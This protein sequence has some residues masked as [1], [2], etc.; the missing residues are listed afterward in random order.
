VSL[1]DQQL[2]PDSHVAEAIDES[3]EVPGH[4]TNRERRSLGSFLNEMRPSVAT[5]GYPATPLVILFVLALIQELDGAAFGVLFPEIRDWFGTD[6]GTTILLGNLAGLLTVAV[7]VPIGYL[8]DRVKRTWFVGIGAAVWAAFTLGIGLSWSIIALSAF[9]FGAGVG[10]A[11]EAPRSSL[12]A[13]YYPPKVRGTVFAF[14][15]MSLPVAAFIAPTLAGV[16][17]DLTGLWQVPFL[18]V[19]VP[20][21]VIALVVIARL[22]EPVRGEQERRALGA[23]EEL[24][25]TEEAPPSLSESLR[26]T[27]G[28]RTLRRLFI[29]LPFIV[30]SISLIGPLTAEVMERKFGL[31]PSVRGILASISQPV[32]IVGLTIGGSLANRL[33]RTKPSKVMLFLGGLTFLSGVSLGIIG[34]L[35]RSLLPLLILFQ[36]V[37]AGAGAVLAPS[38]SA[39][40]TLVVP[41]RVRGF[42]GGVFGVAAA[43]GIAFSLVVAPISNSWGASGGLAALAAVFCVGAVIWM[44]AAGGVEADMRAA[45]ASSMAQEE[46]RASQERGAA[47]LL[48][49]RDVDVHYGNIQILFNVD[50]DVEEGEIIAL[51]GTNG[52]GKS[53]LLRAISGLTTVSNGAIYCNGDDI[54]YLPPNE[55]VGKGIVLVN[56]GRGVFPTLTVAENLKLAAWTL[57]DDGDYVRDATEQV[58][59][60]FPILRERANEPAGNLSGGEQQMLTLAQAFLSRPKLLMIDELSLGLAPAVVERLLEIVRAIHQQGTTIVLVEQSVNVALTVAERAVYMEKGE[61][62]FTGPTAELLERPDVLKSVFLK[63]AAAGAGGAVGGGAAYASTGA[64]YGRVGSKTKERVDPGRE[65][66]LAVRDIH[67]S[68]GGVRALNGMSFTLEQGAIVG[69]IGPNGAG[70]TTI[71]D[72]ISGFVEPDSGVV[73]LFGEDVTDLPPDARARLGLMRSFQDARLFPS[74][75]VAENLAVALERH[76]EQ[77]SAT[78]AALHLPNVRKSEA[79]IARRVERLIELSNLGDFANKFVREL[80]TGSRRIVDLAVVLAADPKVI[81]LDEPSSGVAQR[82]AEELGPLLLRIRYE[83]GCSMLLIEHDMP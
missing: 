66:V 11:M 43:V 82:E 74:L 78:M 53:T 42:A 24:A 77:R 33:I 19:A 75:T 15:G 27:F 44:S 76:V 48:V 50:F 45:L 13:D 41:P 49:C 28:V 64:A 58:Q 14:T 25:L 60:F 37:Q 56:G 1:V 47:K 22:R 79:K 31:S 59:G 35:P 63:G 6:L 69:L 70:K 21:F 5:G 46:I 23:D 68:F 54:T 30:G 40:M 26:A 34:F 8:A 20:G 2:P 29:G 38:A 73:E 16:T 72:V 39:V 7:S 10:K 83:T 55:H 71:F 65:K 61:V 12:L 81:L 67:K 4:V 32:A 52:A 3:P 51:L 80:S 62:R 36:L 57:R 17:Y 9:R 18:L